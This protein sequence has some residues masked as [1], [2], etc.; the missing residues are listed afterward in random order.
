M[1]VKWETTPSS[2][3]LALSNGGRSCIAVPVLGSWWPVWTVRVLSSKTRFT[4]SKSP[5]C[6][7]MHRSHLFNVF[8]IIHLILRFFFDTRSWFCVYRAPIPLR[9]EFYSD[10]VWNGGHAGM[11][12]SGL[13]SF[14][15]S[16][17]F[18]YTSPETLFTKCL[19]FWRKKCFFTHVFLAAAY[20]R[21]VGKGPSGWNGPLRKVRNYIM[22]WDC[23]PL[24]SSPLLSSP[25]SWLTVHTIPNFAHTRATRRRKHTQMI[26]QTNMCP[27][28]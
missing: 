1:C 4:Y 10:W 13:F 24:S 21:K 8:N 7:H 25:V 9:Q 2:P 19:F 15:Y 28:S 20:P 17:Q 6:K 14:L 26:V 27:P 18:H 23:C 12:I 3:L 22:V 5:P 16:S 11:L